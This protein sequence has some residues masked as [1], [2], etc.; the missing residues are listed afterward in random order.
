MNT[1]TPL[2]VRRA[3]DVLYDAIYAKKTHAEIAERAGV[4]IASVHRAYHG[5]NF[6][7]QDATAI[8]KAWGNVRKETLG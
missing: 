4:S 1:P 6:N 7:E 2:I 5:H 3:R 8:V